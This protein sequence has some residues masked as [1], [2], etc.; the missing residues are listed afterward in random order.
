M[1]QTTILRTT[2]ASAIVAL[3]AIALPAS[4]QAQ[5][6]S[7]YTSCEQLNALQDLCTVY[8]Y[9]PLFEQFFVVDVYIVSRGGETPPPDTIE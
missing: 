3:S 9:D 4:A 6:P 1:K 7:S 5:G 8:E 2:I